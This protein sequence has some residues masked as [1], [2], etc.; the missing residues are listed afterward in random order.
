MRLLFDRNLAPRLARALAD[1]FSGSTHVIELG[2]DAADDRTVWTYAATYGLTIVSRDSD[3]GE[4]AVIRGA[5]PRVIWIRRGSCPTNEIEALLRRAY[6][7]ILRFNDDA[8]AA[9]LELM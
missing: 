8:R 2:L 5:L 1:L 3:M 9:V 4:L 7:D 6:D